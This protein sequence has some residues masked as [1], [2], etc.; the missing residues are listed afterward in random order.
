MSSAIAARAKPALDPLVREKQQAELRAAR[1]EE[2][3]QRVLHAKTRIIGVSITCVQTPVLRLPT[4]LASLTWE[5][6]VN[7]PTD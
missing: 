3:R 2:R 5:Q 4:L 1:N 7:T 6:Q